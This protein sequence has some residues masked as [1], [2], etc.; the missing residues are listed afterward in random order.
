MIHRED[1]GIPTAAPSIIRVA[2]YDSHV[3]RFDRKWNEGP[4][5]QM[6]H[7]TGA[8]FNASLA[9][10]TELMNWL[11]QAREVHN[12]KKQVPEFQA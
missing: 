9:H 5:S 7:Q 6:S 4:S 2:A 1:A 8:L 12:T 10:I 3:R 11:R